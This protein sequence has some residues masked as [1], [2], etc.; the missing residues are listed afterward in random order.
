METTDY[1]DALNIDMNRFNRMPNKEFRVIDDDEK[2]KLLEK[3]ITYS[4]IDVII[5]FLCIGMAKF[6]PIENDIKDNFY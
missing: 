3:Q 4:F 6:S 1:K 5:M 2:K